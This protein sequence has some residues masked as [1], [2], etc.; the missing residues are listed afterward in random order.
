MKNPIKQFILFFCTLILVGSINFASADTASDTEILFNWAEN[1]YSQYFPSHQTTQS[2]EPWL[3][4]FYPETTI[5]TGVNTTDNGVY[6]LGGPWGNISPTYI[7]SLPN[8]LLTASSAVIVV[9]GHSDHVNTARPLLAGLPVQYGGTPKP[10]DTVL[11]VVSAQDG[12]MPQ[13]RL[14]AEAV[15]SLPRAMDAI[16]VTKTADV[17]AELLQLVIVEMREVLEQAGDPRWNTMPLLRETDPNIRLTL[18]GLQPLPT[19]RALVTLGQASAVDLAAP[20]LVGLPSRIEPP[21]IA[22]DGLLFV[23]SAQDGPMPQTRQQIEANIGNPHAADAIFLVSVAAQPDR[24]LQ[25]LVI[26]EMRDLLGTMGEPHWDSMPIL[27][28]TDSNVGLTLR[29]LLLPA[30]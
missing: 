24:E 21:S 16:L 23:V 17:D 22:G 5:Y 20:S 11:F 9:L 3:F 28:D 18:R 13:T 6:V 10:V 15:A 19:G 2:S 26:V 14:D 8:L 27:R 1:N 29:G 30:P 7:D 25:E 4:R 12:P